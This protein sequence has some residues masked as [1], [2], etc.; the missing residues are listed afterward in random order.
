MSALRSLIGLNGEKPRKKDP[1]TL[2]SLAKKN[3]A[4]PRSQ[5]AK[6]KYLSNVD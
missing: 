4:V 2:S 5:T 1:K 3:G 6:P